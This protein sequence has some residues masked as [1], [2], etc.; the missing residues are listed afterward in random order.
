MTGLA[1]CSGYEWGVEADCGSTDGTSGYSSTVSFTTGGCSCGVP[2]GVS[3]R[4][5][6]KNK[7]QVSWN[8]VSGATSY[9]AEARPQGSATWTT[10]TTTSTSV[11]FTG[12]SSG[13]TYEYRV[14]TNCNGTFSAYSATDTYNFRAAARLGEDAGVLIYP[15]PVSDKLTIE[16]PEVEAT[17]V[18]IQLIDVLGRVVTEINNHDTSE[19]SVEIDVSNFKS[20]VYFVKISDGKDWNEVSRIVVQ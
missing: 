17:Q 18:Q 11:N 20:G 5:R 3:A 8:S 2:T 19:F 14:R 12:A 6:G 13:T 7:L 9:E 4:K 16:F 15:N 1:T 10:A